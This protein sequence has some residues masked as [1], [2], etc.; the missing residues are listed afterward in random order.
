[1]SPRDCK[2]PVSLQTHATGQTFRLIAQLDLR[3]ILYTLAG[4]Y[5]EI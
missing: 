1:M 4:W 3:N 5:L 2:G